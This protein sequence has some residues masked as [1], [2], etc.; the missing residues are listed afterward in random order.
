[1]AGAYGTA[2]YSAN[3]FLVTCETPGLGPE[4]LKV[5]FPVGLIILEG[6]KNTSYPKIEVLRQGV[7]DGLVSSPPHLAV[8]T[9]GP[10]ELTGVP[11]VGLNEFDRLAELIVLGLSLK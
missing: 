6:G 4:D 2:V 11:K 3:R 8:C 1:M 10:W 9:D 5:H 7:S